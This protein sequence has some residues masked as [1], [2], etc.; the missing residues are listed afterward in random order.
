MQPKEYFSESGEDGPSFSEYYEQVQQQVKT[1]NNSMT[2]F[3]GKGYKT[4]Y[5]ITENTKLSTDEKHQA[6]KHLNSVSWYDAGDLNE[7]RDLVVE[8]TIK[9]NENSRT[10]EADIEVMQIG[11]GW[12]I[13]S[14]ACD[15]LESL[16]N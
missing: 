11:K 1:N 3:F 9:G 7:V 2:S 14:Y 6:T 8:I 4:S 16:L 15:E 10:F 5:Q 12:Y 13:L